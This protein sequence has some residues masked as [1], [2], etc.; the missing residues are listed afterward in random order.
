MG[1][2]KDK[3]YIGAWL[4]ELQE[5]KKKLLK[6]TTIQQAQQTGILEAFYVAERYLFNK[7]NN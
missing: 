7:V 6:T 1:D 5:V 3:A 4:G 2:I